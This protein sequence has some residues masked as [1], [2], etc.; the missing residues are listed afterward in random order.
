[1]IKVEWLGGPEDGAVLSLPDDSKNLKVHLPQPRTTFGSTP[2]PAALA[3]T[4]VDVPIR[5]RPD[6]R[7]FAIWGERKPR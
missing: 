4:T 1:M 6:G 3:P 7:A 2:T 5:K